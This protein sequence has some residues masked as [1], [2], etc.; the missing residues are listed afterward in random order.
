MMLQSPVISVPMRFSGKDMAGRTIAIGDIH[1]C[2][3][4]LSSL[5]E[6]F[7]PTSED[8]IITLGDYID[9]GPDSR[10]V[11]DKLIALSN[12][13]QLIPLLGNHEERLF[14]ALHSTK[15]LKRWLVNGGTDTLRS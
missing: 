7:A 9:R 8:T 1:G 12:R 4:A 2:S 6:A 3:V 10:G 14:D 13:C 5:I 15:Y 11:L